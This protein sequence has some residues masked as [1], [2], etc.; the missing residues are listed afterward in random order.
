MRSRAPA[1][2]RRPG[3][4]PW[5]ATIALALL[6]GAPYAHAA[7]AKGHGEHARHENDEIVFVGCF[8]ELP[9][10]SGEEHDIP[11][12]QQSVM[13][14]PTTTEGCA[15]RCMHSIYFALQD[16]VCQCTSSFGSTP[17]TQKLRDPSECGAPCPGEEALQPTRLCGLSDAKGRRRNAVYTRTRCA[18][19]ARFVV[20]KQMENDR[21]GVRQW[22]AKIIFDEW[23]QGARI[24]LDWGNVRASSSHP[25]P[26][27]CAQRVCHCRS[28]GLH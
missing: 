27:A 9:A 14:P 2:A 4:L 16:G 1:P 19:G 26:A 20:E 25:R 5:H 11:G 24:V 23:E 6:Y 21:M 22:Q 7:T 13:R 3:W 17:N 10:D 8:A 28:C 18:L 15:M 12:W